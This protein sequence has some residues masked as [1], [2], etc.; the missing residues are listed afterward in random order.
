[1][2]PELPPCVVGV[3]GCRA[4]WV[5][6]ALPA[7]SGQP[8]RPAPVFVAKSFRETRRWCD[9][10][11]AL[12]VGVDM[13]IGLPAN[14]Q[15]DSDGLARRRLGPRRSSFFPTPAHAVL[16]AESWD[17]ALALSRQAS[18]KGIS[19]QAFNLMPKVRQIRSVIRP[20]DQPRFSEVHPET[21]FAVMAAQAG[22]APL[23]PK[24][25]SE[26]KRQRQGLLASELGE[27]VAQ[28]ALNHDRAA[29]A[30]DEDVLDALAAAWTARRMVSG[31]AEVLGVGIDPD[32]FALTVTV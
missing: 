32:G 12:A 13:P 7:E 8:L 21:S 5:A 3:D 31:E 15:R 25:M 2:A 20:A 4:G 6:V 11:G 30:S 18:G 16:G 17:E 9:E 29:G 22:V 10:I 1:M 27:V 14:G 26:G 19:K 24:K 23:Q 28:A